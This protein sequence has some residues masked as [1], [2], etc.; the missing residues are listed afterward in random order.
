MTGASK[1]LTVSY[2]TF[3]CTLEGFDDPLT[4]MKFIAE[5]FRDLAAEDRYF[6]SEPA[7]P[8]A[9][10]MHRIAERESNR[11]VEAT[12]QNNGGVLLRATGSE[13]STPQVA[14][15]EPP[16][17]AVQVH[18]TP[19]PAPPSPSPNAQAAAFVA[20]PTGSRVEDVAAKLMRIRA[21]AQS[22]ADV[23]APAAPAP[24]KLAPLVLDVTAIAPATQKPLDNLFPEKSLS[25]DPI[26][27]WRLSES[28]GFMADNPEDDDA[29]QTDTE[30]SFDADDKLAETIKAA[31]SMN[32]ALGP[33]PVAAPAPPPPAPAQRVPSFVFDDDLDDLDEEEPDEPDTAVREPANAPTSA[34]AKI[35]LAKARLIKIRRAAPTERAE[36]IAT[37]EG[38][39]MLPDTTGDTSI[40]RLIA[41]TNSEMD[42]PEQRARWSAIAHLKAAVAT[43][44]A[45]REARGGTDLPDNLT[46]VYK[47]EFTKL[48]DPS[49][50]E[51]DTDRPAPLVLVSEQRIDRKAADEAAHPLVRPRR[52]SVSNLALNNLVEPISYDFAEEEDEDEDDTGDVSVFFDPHDFVEFA[53]RLGAEDMGELIQAAGVY[54]A[55]IECRPH[56]SPLHLIRQITTTEDWSH[57]AQ[58]EGLRAFGA[59]MREGKIERVRKGQYIVTDQS[60]YMVEAQRILG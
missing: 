53:N 7:T 54:A 56:F 51:S 27:E 2:G 46:E 57:F 8:D 21:S 1:I 20:P 23:A 3:S 32:M 38:A 12:V 5:Y 18:P 33:E 16:E 59:L 4:T 47:D 52:V 14:I 26:S 50:P 44:V 29:D 55:L 22:E 31:M 11:R 24:E 45:D 25:D 37:S 43:T 49:E 10:M 15:D 40:N 35:K 41:Q 58:E 13:P 36:T 28:D 48:V 9:A 17:A 60:E 19:K 34:L 30:T 39:R 6:G 42:V